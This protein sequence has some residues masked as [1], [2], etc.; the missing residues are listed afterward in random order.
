MMAKSY[1]THLHVCH[2]NIAWVLSL[3]KHLYTDTLSAQID[4]EF[5]MRHDNGFLCEGLSKS[6]SYALAYG[7]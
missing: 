5:M 2:A 6:H 1:G 7:L 4:T 3:H